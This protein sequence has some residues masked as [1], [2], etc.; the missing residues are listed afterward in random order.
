MIPRSKSIIGSGHFA[1]AHIIED[2]FNKI[3]VVFDCRID[4]CRFGLKS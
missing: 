3:G 4:G 2:F 1:V